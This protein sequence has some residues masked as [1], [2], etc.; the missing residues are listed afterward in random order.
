MTI[1]QLHDSSVEINKNIFTISEDVCPDFNIFVKSLI[2]KIEKN[3]IGTRLLEKIQQLSSQTYIVHGEVDATYLHTDHTI[4]GKRPPVA[5]VQLSGKDQTCFS[6]S[7][8]SIPIPQHVGLFHELTHAYHYLSDKIATTRFS[9]PFIWKTDEEYKT[10]IGLP[11]KNGKKTPKI[12]E[13][14]YRKAEGLSE[15]F[16]SW[17]PPISD[18]RAAWCAA[19]IKLLGPI[20]E[21]NQSMTP[22]NLSPPQVDFYSVKDLGSETRPMVSAE[23]YGVGLDFMPQDVEAYLCDIPPDA[24]SKARELESMLGEK[25]HLDL[26]EGK[27][28]EAIN[29]LAVDFFPKLSAINFFQVRSLNL[30][31]IRKEE[32]SLIDAL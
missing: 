11:S 2:E 12:T 20:Y 4:D 25:C 15:R 13:N 26:T 8:A 16:G 21:R 3:P 7:G 28:I 5:I 32:E 30:V 24:S 27:T 14:A 17:S 6:T 18:L 1:S 23:I 31:R 10:I 22:D 9:D 19:R 29:N